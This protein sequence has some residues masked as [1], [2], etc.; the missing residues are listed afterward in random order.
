MHRSMRDT[1]AVKAVTQLM[2]RILTG[3]SGIQGRMLSAAWISLLL[4][5]CLISAHVEADDRQPPVIQLNTDDG[6][7][8][9]I[10]PARPEKPAAT[11]IVL[12]TT[13]EATLGNP[14]YRQAGNVLADRGYLL[15]TIDLPCH[16]RQKRA[17]EPEGID[18]WRYRCDHGENFV[19]DLTAR[20]SAVLT[21]LITNRLTDPDR[22]AVCGTSRGGFSAIQFAAADPRV[23]CVAAFAPVT[24]LT[25]LREFQGA[26]DNSFVRSLSLEQCAD[27]L[28]GRSVWLIIGDRDVRV[29]TDS[30]IQFARKVTE[31][32][33]AQN[34]SA[35]FDL[36]V[37]AEPKGHTTPAMAPEMGAEWILKHME[38]QETN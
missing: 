25:K 30:A 13:I 15:V 11:L 27:K 31:V 5:F 18:G 12:A 34:Q 1:T 24:D 16:G 26:E 37:V 20:M 6:I 32:S 8:F 28:A 36:H 23:R 14:Y 21:W 35:R 33:L 3:I 19:S 2:N 17:D 4:Q 7:E 22:I 10:W 9:G 29:S 38:T